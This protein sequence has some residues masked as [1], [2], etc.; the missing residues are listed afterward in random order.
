VCSSPA[1]S[2]SRKN[3]P[4]LEFLNGDL[5]LPW[6]EAVLGLQSSSLANDL[7]WGRRTQGAQAS[8]TSQF[9]ASNVFSGSKAALATTLASR[10]VYPG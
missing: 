1:M 4:V 3:R 9:R 6:A 5:V 10:P 8:T 7:G 2:R